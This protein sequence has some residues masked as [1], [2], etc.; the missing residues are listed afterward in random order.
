M[1]LLQ[2]FGAG[3]ILLAKLFTSSIVFLAD[4]VELHNDEVSGI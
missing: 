3:V 1:N 4:G 2:F